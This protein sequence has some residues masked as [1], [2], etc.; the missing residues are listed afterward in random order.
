[1]P[2]VI[3]VG[4][5]LAGL[6]AA[7]ALGGA[8]F[9]V[10]L[11]ESRG[12]LG[13]RATS[14]PVSPVDESDVIDNC[15]H[16]LLRCCVNLLDFYR[17]LGADQRIRFY[18]EYNFLEPGGRLS[19][20]R[21]SQM[22]APLHLASAFLRMKC[23][24][25][26]DK[27]AIGAG[28][29][30]IERERNRKDL[31][32]ITMMEWLREKH[33]TNNAIERFW[34]QILVSAVNEDLDLMAASHG[35]QVFWLGMLSRPEAFEMGI[36]DVPLRE[37]YGQGAW[38]GVGDVRIHTRCAVERIVIEAGAVAGVQVGG[39]LRTADAY[40]CALPFEKV[41]AVAPGLDID[42]S[43]FQH[44]PITG[45]HLW[46]DRPVTDL[47]HAALLDRTIQ[48]MFN[49]SGGRYVQF[50]VSASRCLI[51]LSRPEV[52]DLALRD[53]AEFFPLMREAKLERAQVIKELRAT[54]SAAP[55][56]EACRPG[57]ATK[58]PGLFLAGDWTRS[59]WPAT[60]EGAVRSGYLAAEAVSAAAGK[61]AKFLLP[62]I[63]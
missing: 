45:I 59:G 56:L 21:A 50:V 34:R 10:D 30:S 5:G 26:A 43:A 62:D 27:I 17:R 61:P 53:G 39:E 63:A 37:L 29:L 7:A 23:F 47:P 58:I 14:F 24:S 46:F 40:V 2:S 60:M 31:D 54:F 52:V 20:L 38:S 3:V 51:Q 41:N 28:M 8:G 57:A 19:T 42:T 1:M 55:G 18:N 48:W 13:G 33:Q 9:S 22:P 11:Y 12:F 25:L 36:P 6:S 32:S 4:G 35:F 16:V 44:S 15:Q 49:K